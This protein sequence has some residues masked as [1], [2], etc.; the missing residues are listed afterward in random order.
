MSRKWLKSG[1]VMELEADFVEARNHAAY[2][3]VHRITSKD[4][5]GVLMGS[6]GVIEIFES[7]IEQLCWCSTTATIGD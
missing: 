4:L 5:I 3:N 7:N 2:G 1:E 6:Y